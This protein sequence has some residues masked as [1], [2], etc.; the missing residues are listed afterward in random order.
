MKSS[1]LSSVF[2]LT[3]LLVLIHTSVSA[4]FN[5]A[6]VKLDLSSEMKEPSNATLHDYI[7]EDDA[8][9]YLLR[10]KSKRSFFAVHVAEYILESHN[11]KSF[12]VSKMQELAPEVEGD[13]AGINQII[14]LNEQL[15]ALISVYN[16]KKDQI[17]LYVQSINKNTLQL[18]G[19][20]K[21]LM[22]MPA[23]S[24]RN[25]G[26]FNAKLSRDHKTVAVFGFVADEKQTNQRY[27]L[28]V[29][30]DEMKV[31]WHKDITLPYDSKLFATERSYCDND[32]NAYILGR[33]Y[34]EIAKEKRSG[35]PN[36]VYKMLA[37]RDEGKD[38]KEYTLGLKDNFITDVS[39]GVTDDGKLICAG[40]YS[41]RGTFSIKGTYCMQ[42][43][44]ESGDVLKEGTKNFDPDFLEMFRPADKKGKEEKPD[45]KE[46]KDSKKSRR[47]RS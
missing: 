17:E 22:A 16:K 26:S 18:S 37:Y 29:M 1:I 7:G 31:K 25:E 24:K 30:D 21:Q 6:D 12:G 20:P 10:E 23:K 33:L 46:E 2:R 44:V 3:A 9:Y 47:G 19:T 43:D 8:N 42:I 40:F 5:K 38:F 36:Y 34:K 15:F 45:K 28:V 32:G 4:Q 39:F 13:D 27:N 14:M 35:E 41:T 11:K